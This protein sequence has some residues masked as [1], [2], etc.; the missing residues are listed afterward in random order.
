M[1]KS[2]QV[3][4]V[5]GEQAHLQC[6]ALG[7]TPMEIL[8]KIGGQ[9]I[10]DQGDQHYSIRAQQLAEGMVSELSIE[11]AIRQDTAIFTCSAGNAYGSDDMNIQLI[12]QEIPEPPRNVR[13][14]DQLSRSIG[15]SWTQPYSGNSPITNY[16]I[17]YKPAS[18][19]YLSFLND[20]VDSNKQTIKPPQTNAR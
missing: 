8:W 4:V 16:I 1:Q 13:V 17:Q 14:M 2:K 5:R 10:S 9:Q 11:R 20:I 7:D 18:G 6:S 15:I 3:Q 12:V 19:N